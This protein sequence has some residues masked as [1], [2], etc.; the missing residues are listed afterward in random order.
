MRPA[1]VPDA[2]R[3]GY[4][5]RVP[6]FLL[7][8][9]LAPSS[10]LRWLG[11]GTGPSGPVDRVSVS[12]AGGTELTLA[13]DLES[14][15]GRVDYPLEF[16]GVGDT[17][18][19]VE[20]TSWKSHPELG[21]FPTGHRVIIGNRV[22][23]EVSYSRIRVNDTT[24][25]QLLRIPPELDAVRSPA[26]PATPPPTSMPLRAARPAGSVES[27]G[28]GVFLVEDL[29]GFDLMFVD[30]GGEVLAVD[31]PAAHPFLDAIPATNYT[32]SA[33][34]SRDYIAAIRRTL[35]GL[36]I[37]YLVLTHHH[38]DHLGGLQE[39]IGARATIITPEGDTAMVRRLAQA[40]HRLKSG[41]ARGPVPRIETVN[42][43]RVI[44]GR[45][46]SVEIFQ[47]GPNPHTHD[48]LLIWIPGSR[49]LFQGDLF[50]H[51]QGEAP[52]PDRATM[53]RFFAEWVARHDLRPERIYGVHN[54]GFATADD[55]KP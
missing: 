18:A 1:T 25:A 20:Y 39:F 6:H 30:L 8:E 40:P 43:R 41:L 52:P 46:R 28:D 17:R 19:A 48:N 29:G 37:R 27:L 44:A 3:A 12:L 10:T 45:L 54:D 26:R 21:R 49:T 47:V 22:Y 31:A 4:R 33:P 24:T 35:P 2:D 5:R 23:Q 42:G 55:L 9:A 13:F 11:R 36:P 38:S 53:N 51:N 32:T 15:L 50:Y 7:Q 34:V 16:P 14:Q